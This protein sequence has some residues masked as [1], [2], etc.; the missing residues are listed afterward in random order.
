M[1]LAVPSLPRNPNY[2]SVVAPGIPTLG[3]TVSGGVKVFQLTAEP[4]TIQ[5]PDM[6]DGMGMKNRPIYVWGYNGS[7]IGPTI[8]A[9][10]G[11]TVRIIVRNNLP[12][13]T[14]IH[15]H[16]LEIPIDMDGV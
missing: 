9:V 10:E 15:W 11:D 8:E 13:P 7:M 3:Y 5:F 16:G 12:E 6:S 2:V 1:G 14:T 4:V